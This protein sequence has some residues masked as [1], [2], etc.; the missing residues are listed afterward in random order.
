MIADIGHGG[1]GTVH[2]AEDRRLPGRHCAV[3]THRP[4]AGLPPSAVRDALDRFAE[5]ARLLARLDHPALPKVSDHFEDGGVGYL[6]MDF[7]PGQD[8]AAILGNAIGRDRRLPV[9]TVLGW[10][11]ALCGALAYL[12]RMRPPIIHRDVKPAN[13][14]LTPDGQLRL[15]DFGLARTQSVGD[16]ITVTVSG[17]GSRAFQ[18]L[19]QYGDAASVDPRA[20]VYAVGATLWDLLVGRLPASAQERFLDRSALLDLMALRSDVP[21]AVADVIESAMALH[22]D[23]RPMDAH[24]LRA[25][26]RHA[27]RS[28]PNGTSEE[29][30]HPTRVPERWKGNTLW[31]TALAGLVVAAAWLSLAR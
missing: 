22:P 8:L 16:G 4:P 29:A 13:I 24:D 19:E 31:L 3:K 17:G 9:E 15:V 7:V 14:K 6:V 5:E 2:L 12:H 10:A 25:R 28:L 1:M 20:D 23:D 26:L 11:D 18:P 30:A 21:R 27:E